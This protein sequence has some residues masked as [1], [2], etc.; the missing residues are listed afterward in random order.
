ML[1]YS[2]YLL[3]NLGVSSWRNAL[4]IWGLSCLFLYDPNSPSVNLRATNLST[5]SM[6]MTGNESF[7]TAIHSS[8]VNGVIWNTACAKEIQLIVK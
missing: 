4:G 8:N 1:R 2:R 3:T 7:K 6:S 5:S